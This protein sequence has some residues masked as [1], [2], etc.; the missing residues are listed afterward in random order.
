MRNGRVHVV[1]NGKGA[2]VASFASR[3]AISS[4]VVPFENTLSPTAYVDFQPRNLIDTAFASRVAG[5][6]SGNR[7]ASAMMPH[8]CVAPI[9]ILSGHTFPQLLKLKPSLATIAVIDAI[10]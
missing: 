5:A 7:R 3:V 9:W 10:V 1:G 4:V 6:A 2:V 8:F